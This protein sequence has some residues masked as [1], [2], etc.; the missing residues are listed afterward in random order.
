[1]L[2]AQYSDAVNEST[3]SFFLSEISHSDIPL[4]RL[5]LSLS[6]L[7]PYPNDFSGSYRPL[8]T[9][10]SRLAQSRDVVTCRCG[11]LVGGVQ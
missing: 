1:M 6:Q 3:H 2:T 4:L 5:S 7:Q 9:G 8:V 10:L 11:V